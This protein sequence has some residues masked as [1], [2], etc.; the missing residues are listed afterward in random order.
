MRYILAPTNRHVLRQFARSR[1]LLAFDYDGTLAP[2]VSDPNQAV[3][4]ASTRALLRRLAGRY[5]CVVISGRSRADALRRLRGVPL[6]EVVGNHGVEPWQASRRTLRA[7]RQWQPMLARGL[8]RWQGVKIEDKGYSIA[9]HYRRSREKKVV[10][11]AIQRVA[12]RLGKVRLIPGKEVV[13]VLP[14]DAPHK[15][16]ALE[17][18]RARFR[19]DAAVYVGDDYTDEDVF[20]LEQADQLLTIRVGRKKDSLAAYY[21]RDQAGIDRLL[22]SFLAVRPERSASSL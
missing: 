5:P 2:I 16:I 6:V 21:L 19:C 18:A 17:T 20:A 13:N 15:G 14:D 22:R 7:V 4:R 12:S 11:R 1:V 10:R 9:V 3:M 8:A